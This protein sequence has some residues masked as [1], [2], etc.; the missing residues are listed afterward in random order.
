MLGRPDSISEVYRRTN[1][2]VR[3]PN[4]DQATTFVDMRKQT[5]YAKI[6]EVIAF[7]SSVAGG[8]AYLTQ[9]TTATFDI[10][11]VYRSQKVPPDSHELNSLARSFQGTL[12]EIVMGYPIVVMGGFAVMAEDDIAT[13]ISMIELLLKA[14]F[15]TLPEGNVAIGYAAEDW[16]GVSRNQ[17]QQLLEGIVSGTAETLVT[18]DDENGFF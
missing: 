6:T 18:P 17:L 11:L 15:E 4:P 5:C 1:L 8:Y 9:E 13:R 10:V 14:G 12:H 7:R 3:R 2:A 16:S